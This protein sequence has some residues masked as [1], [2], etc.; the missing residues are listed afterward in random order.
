MKMLK[1]ICYT[2]LLGISCSVFAN[3]AKSKLEALAKG[4][5]S[6]VT[7]PKKNPDGTLRSLLIIGRANFNKLMDED[8]AEE[9]ARENANINASIALSEYFNKVVTVSR[10]RKTATL[11]KSSASQQGENVN[12]NASVDTINVKSQEFSSLSKAAIAGM[13]EIFA[14]VYNNKYVIIYAWDKEECKQLKDIII[15][16][17]E[18]AQTAIKE[19]KDAESRLHAPTGTPQQPVSNSNNGTSKKQRNSSVSDGGSASSDAD[20]Y[21]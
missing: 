2:L 5:I 6:G 20:N 9:D 12:K 4:R 15:T 19:A 8:E 10:K 16:M 1:I 7:N 21:I 13:K 14:A 18:T 3:S 17:S 11:T